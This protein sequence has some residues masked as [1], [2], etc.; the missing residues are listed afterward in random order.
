ML[1]SFVP[2][3]LVGLGL[4]VAVG[5]ATLWAEAG[6]KRRPQRQDAESPAESG[7]GDDRAGAARPQP[8]DEDAEGE[9]EED[10]RPWERPGAVRRDC[11]PDRGTTLL[12]LGRLSLWLLV[13][14]VLLGAAV[15]VP[16]FPLAIAVLVMA[17]RDRA[18][19]RAGTMDPAGERLTRK[20]ARYAQAALATV[21]LAVLTFVGLAA[22]M[23]ALTDF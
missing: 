2:V 12:W 8:S 11:E 18:K 5:G 9:A 16:V 1:A 19:M 7:P 15:L 14:G 13:L 17:S 21:V 4:L 22:A 20:G 6:G 3:C 10:E 23:I